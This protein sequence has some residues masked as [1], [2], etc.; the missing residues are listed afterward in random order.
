MTTEDLLPTRPHRPF[1]CACPS[2]LKAAGV[3]VDADDRPHRLDG[4]A[5][6]EGPSRRLWMR[7]GHLH[8]T[9][10]PAQAW[11]DIVWAIE[12]THAD[13][14]WVA[15]T[16]VTRHHPEAPTVVVDVMATLCDS[17]AEGVDSMDRFYYVALA[18][19][20]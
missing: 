10:G 5:V 4:P 3:W 18:A 9:D 1:E 14:E 11:G 8:R 12:G 6:D 17:W 2:F 20:A 19:T 13:T 7:H 15:R 16:W